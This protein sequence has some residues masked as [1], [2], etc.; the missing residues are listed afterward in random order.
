MMNYQV[1]NLRGTTVPK[2][3]SASEA[4]NNLGA[5]IEWAVKN[6]D[7]VI[8]ESRGKAKVVILPFE[9]YEEY[10]RLREQARRRDVLAR[11]ERLAEIVGAQ[12]QDLSAEEAQTLA[13]QLSQEV[14]EEMAA[15]G[16]IR[17]ER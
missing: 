2:T 13:A 7:E 3:V 6:Q 8:V 4:K 17:Y 11:L 16:K 10:Q 14:I 1:Q 5:M 9:G 15:E 12:N